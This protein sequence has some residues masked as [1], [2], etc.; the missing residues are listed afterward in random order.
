ME[1]DLLFLQVDKMQQ[2]FGLSTLAVDDIAKGRLGLQ[3]ENTHLKAHVLHQVAGRTDRVRSEKGGDGQH[4]LFIGQ[5]MYF[6]LSK[7]ASPLPW[8]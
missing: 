8:L 6:Q 2:G 1:N 4:S 5:T 3:A 7:L